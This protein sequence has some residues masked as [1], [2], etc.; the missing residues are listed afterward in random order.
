MILQDNGINFCYV[1][2]YVVNNVSELH[3]LYCLRIGSIIFGCPEIKYMLVCVRTSNHTYRGV[4]KKSCSVLE[5]TSDLNKRHTYLTELSAG[6]KYYTFGI[7]L[8]KKC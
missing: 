7:F 3:G 5:T 1:T 6:L 4:K 2:T 8:P